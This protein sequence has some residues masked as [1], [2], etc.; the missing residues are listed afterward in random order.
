MKLIKVSEDF[1][2]YP[3][4]R[5]RDDGDFSGQVFRED[6]LKPA[7]QSNDLVKVDLDGAMG[8]GSSFLEEAFGGLVREEGFDVQT[9]EKKLQIISTEEPELISEIMEYI[10]DN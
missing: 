8:F 4:G 3:A 10:R 5:Y 9:L 2:K 6:F 1:S 7:L